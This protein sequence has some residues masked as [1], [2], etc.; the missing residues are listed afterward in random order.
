MEAGDLSERVGQLVQ[1]LSA[2]G[3]MADM[4]VS[5]E[6]VIVLQTYNCPYHE[7]AQ[8]YRDICEMDERFMREVLGSDVNLSECMLDGH[9]RCTFVVKPDAASAGES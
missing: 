3:V 9:H 6:D 5:E 2:R 8:E 1:A 4:Q 7:I